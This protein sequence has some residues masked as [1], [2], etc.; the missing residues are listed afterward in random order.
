MRILFDIETDGF[1]DRLTKVHTM[2][3]VDVDDPSDTIRLAHGREEIKEVFNKATVV[4]GHHIIGFD[5]PALEKVYKTRI[6]CRL[7]DTYW[8]ASYL[9]YDRPRQGLAHWGEDFGVPKPKVDD[10][11]NLTTEEYDH[12]CIEDVKI[13]LQLFYLI[14]DRLGLLYKDDPVNKQRFIEYTSFKGQLAYHQAQ[15]G[16]HLDVEGAEALAKQLEEEKAQKF[17]LLSHAMPLNPRY[18]ERKKPTVILKACGSR[19]VAGQR[20]FDLLKDEG[21]HESTV[22]PIKVVKEHVPAN[23]NSHQQIKDWLFSLGWQ[24]KTFDYKKDKDGNTKEIPQVRTG[25]KELCPSVLELIDRDPAVKLLDGYTVV[26][27]RLTIV[28][29]FLSAVQ[30]DGRVTAVLK[31]LTNTLRFKHAAPLVN[32]P[33][34]DK[35]Y[36]KEIRSLLKAPDGHVLSGTD[37]VSLEDTTKRH[38]MTPLDPEYCA[39]MEQEG[40]DPHLDLAKF[41]GA[42][43]EQEIQLGG[44]KVKSIRK[45]Y[46]AANYACVY[47][48]GCRT[49]SRATG[50]SEAQAS[51]LIDA[52]WKRNWA[53]K[54]VTDSIRRRTLPASVKHFTGETNWVWNPVS[55][56]WTY[57]KEEKDVWSTINQST[58]VY[59]FD[60][61]VQQLTKHG[62]W[63]IGQFHDEVIL[64]CK[65]T[66]LDREHLSSIQVDAMSMTNH[67]LKLNVTLGCDIQ[68]G[69]DYSEIH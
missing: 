55:Q 35:P 64:T 69:S 59:C 30:P 50:L 46:K 8:L 61:W 3:W 52:Y 49:L 60:T 31:G 51:D 36:G 24:P 45:N 11:E 28:Q 13:N 6:D 40:W 10:W 65:D 21:L 19:T 37:M 47:G 12:R 27:H 32:L 14:D 54:D 23:P 58:G 56:F 43:T 53:V 22:G 41:A 5:I 63:P 38:Y 34:V 68:Y 42:I 39:A 26:S 7:V 62:V 9:W 33:G 29:G 2:A 57:L 20:W 25:S 1:L 48:V 16:W 4:I 18:V 17:D 44:D 15:Q 66:P 67:K